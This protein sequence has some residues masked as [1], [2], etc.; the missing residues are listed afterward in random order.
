MKIVYVATRP[1]VNGATKVAIMHCNLLHNRGHEVRLLVLGANSLDWGKPQVNVS[2]VSSFRRIEIDEKE[3]IVVLDCFSANWFTR[4]YGSERVISLIQTD[5]P[6][7]Y[8]NPE[9]IK[10]AQEAF[11]LPNPKIAVS[12]YLQEVLQRYGSDSCIIPP[13]IDNTIFYPEERRAPEKGKA[14]TVLTVGSYG[15]PLKQIQQAFEALEYLKKLGID[16]KLIRLIRKEEEEVPKDIETKWYVNSRQEDIGDIYRLSDVLLFPSS[17]EGF[18]L[19]I[20]EAMMSGIPFVATDNGGSREIAPD[21]VKE[22]L[23]TVGDTKKMGEALYELAT[24]QEYWKQL[25]VLGLEKAKQWSWNES[26]IRL[27][28]YLKAIYD[29]FIKI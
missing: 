11:A 15:H 16:V 6:K 9:L 13:A 18:G 14:F 12:K 21:Q 29:K 27:E 24:N 25:R 19:P 28:N 26:G 23:V 5:E 10:T 20:L 2:Y 1:Q 3:L 4:K 7:L 17:S 8:A 22:S